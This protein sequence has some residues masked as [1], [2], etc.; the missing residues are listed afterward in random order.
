MSHAPIPLLPMPR[1]LSRSQSRDRSRSRSPERRRD[2]PS[3]A[4]P[5][6]E[7]D[8]FLKNA[9][10]RAWLHEEKRKVCLLVVGTST[11]RLSCDSSTLMNCRGTSRGGMLYV[12][13]LLDAVITLSC[14]SYFRKFVKAWNRSKLSS[15]FLHPL[16]HCL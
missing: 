16:S 9:E 12:H 2:L 13:S 8:Y 1:S 7:S 6:S 4:E 11:C 3:G 15:V 14:Y 5:I 10:F